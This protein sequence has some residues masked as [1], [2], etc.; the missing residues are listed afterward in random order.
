MEVFTDQA[1]EIKGILSEIDSLSS[2]ES[3]TEVSTSNEAKEE[4]ANTDLKQ[5]PVV[6]EELSE[7]PSPTLKNETKAAT[8]EN[9][10]VQT[11]VEEPKEETKKEEPV[12]EKVSTSA[13]NTPPVTAVPPKQYT[14]I[15][16]PK[17]KSKAWWIILILLIL[18]IGAGF[19]AY[20]SSSCVQCWVKYDL[21]SETSREKLDNCTNSIASWFASDKDIDKVSSIPAE[22][23]VDS[24]EIVE[25][26][27]SLQILFDT[28][29][30]YPEYLGAERITNGS[31]LT[32]FALRY[33]GCRDFWVYIYEANRT[34][35]KHP[36]EVAIGTLIRV[37][38]VDP[39]LIDA[40]NPRALKYAKELHDLY[41][42]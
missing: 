33:Y 14:K 35:I 10:S 6:K 2:E 31:S 18:I 22:S 1:N 39:R 17:K 3:S 4:V 29:R 9:S 7:S 5:N 30:V 12:V 40:E 24:T 38:K 36:N 11:S 37:P 13:D 27:D 23:V 25:P 19:V 34:R 8:V 16:E 42:K 28:K 32:R 15:V 20:Y 21:L 41:L 26:V